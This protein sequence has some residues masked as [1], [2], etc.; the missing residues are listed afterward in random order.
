[1]EFLYW[2]TLSAYRDAIGERRRRG[3]K[4]KRG[5]LKDTARILKANYGWKYGEDSYTIRRF[6]D[7]AEKIWHISTR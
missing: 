7:R 3:Q 6:L 5:L 2:Q 1:M 4:G